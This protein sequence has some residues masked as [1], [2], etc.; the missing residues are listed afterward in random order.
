[1]TT[2]TNNRFITISNLN[3]GE[4]YVFR[5]AAHNVIGQGPLSTP[6]LISIPSNNISGSCNDGDVRLRNGTSELEGRVE[7]CSFGMWGTVCDDAWD[8]MNANVVCRQ[9]GFLDTG[10]NFFIII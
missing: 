9:L 6:L 4:S 7:I 5:V 2:D 1:M 10:N 8:E 3:P